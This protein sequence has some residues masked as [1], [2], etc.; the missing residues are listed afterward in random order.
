MAIG[1]R[2]WAIA[3][4]YIPAGSQ[5]PAPE[6]ISHETLCVLN[7][8]DR[9]ANVTVTLYFA[10]RAPAGPYRFVVPAERT[11]HLRSTI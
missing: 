5:G 9:E 11:H 8:G 10:D 6:M 1:R 7:A 3:E 4:G 2:H